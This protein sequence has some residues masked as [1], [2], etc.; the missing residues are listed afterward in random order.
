MHLGKSPITTHEFTISLKRYLTN[1]AD[2]TEG[3]VEEILNKLVK[4]NYLENHRD[5]YQ[6]HGEGDVKRNVLHRI[7][8]EKLIESGTAFKEEGSKFVLKNM[9]IGFFGEHFTKKAIVVVDDEAE[10]KRILSSLNQRHQ[11]SIKIAQINDTLSFITIDKLSGV[12]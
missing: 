12:L 6:L 2:I 3:N 1:G 11:A 7:V 10:I 4:S 5:Y 9:E 8:R